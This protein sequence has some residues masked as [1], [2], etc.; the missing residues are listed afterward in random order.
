MINTH[1]YVSVFEIIEYIYS[2]KNSLKL[3]FEVRVLRINLVTMLK[4]ISLITVLSKEVQSLNL[5]II[6]F[7]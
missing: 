6:I 3:I 5:K 2:G 4:D 1:T 7:S